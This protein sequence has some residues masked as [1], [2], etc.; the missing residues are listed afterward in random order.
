MATVNDSINNIRRVLVDESDTNYQ[1]TELYQYFNDAIAYLSQELA[2][3]NSRIG[4]T[5]TTLSYAQYAYYAFLPSDFLALAMNEE[6]LPRVFNASD[7][8][9][10]LSL[11][12]PDSMDDWENEDND[13]N[14]TVSEFILSGA[15]MHVHP[16]ASAAT[17]IKIYYHPLE[18]IT[19]TS[20]TMPW[21]SWFDRAIEA[22]V[23]RQCRL[24]SEMFNYSGADVADYER[25]K[26]VAWDILQLRENNYPRL[27]PSAGV[28]WTT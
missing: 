18:T 10:R 8:Y 6:G 26:A 21:S 3:W 17:T 15:L 22:F 7:S 28:G 23:I 16:R 19:D 24:R 13:D 5:N 4:L 1:D 20:S 12:G 25:L 14:G 2:R 11:V 9:N 27:K